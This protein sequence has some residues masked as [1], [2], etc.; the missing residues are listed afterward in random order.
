MKKILPI[1]LLSFCFALVYGQSSEVFKQDIVFTIDELGDAN[2]EISSKLTARQ[3]QNWENAYGKKN[4]SILKRDME[5][6]LSYFYLY[7]FD[8][9]QDEM[10]RSYKLS[11]KAKGLARYLGNSEWRADMGMKDPDFSKLTDNSYLVTST[12]TETGMVIQQNNKIFFPEGSSD[13][14]E[15][16]DEFGLAVF[17]Y[18]LKPATSGSPLFLY[19]GIACIVLAV[20]AFLLFGMKKS[21]TA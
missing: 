7:D 17:E 13:V 11:F 2:I 6:S 4:V 18:K 9:E 15:D 1:I 14:E 5:R 3:W 21:A 16:T 20:V 12:L 10:E 19:I 8:Y